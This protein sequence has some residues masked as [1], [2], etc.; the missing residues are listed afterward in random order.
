MG[1]LRISHVIFRTSSSFQ[2]LTY[3]SMLRFEASEMP[4]I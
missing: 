3:L 4:K 2:I 1:R